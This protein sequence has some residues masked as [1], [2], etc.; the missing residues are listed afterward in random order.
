[1]RF[2]LIVLSDDPFDPPGDGRY[3]GAHLF[4]FDL[5]R[6]LVRAGHEV[7]YLTRKSRADK[8]LYQELGPCCR[9][10]RI[11]VGPE[12]EKDHHG[13]GTAMDKIDAAII[14]SLNEE[15]KFDC[16]FSYNWVSGLAAKHTGIRPHIHHILSL[17]RVRLELG[18]EE[19][20]SD[21]MRDR[22][23]IEVFTSASR[24][25]CV[26]PDEFHS[27]IRLYPE[28]DRRVAVII[29]YGVDENEFTP[30]PTTAIDF[31]RGASERFAQGVG[32]LY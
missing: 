31:L 12:D 9:L 18:E 21:G 14:R 22:G 6:H 13:L 32:T 23:E 11:E 29:P 27:L 15:G 1:M 7:V 8:P 20:N 30:R 26:C 17:G 16:V 4:S 25:I 19:H 3:G 5:G 28:V 24:L 10:H 2:L